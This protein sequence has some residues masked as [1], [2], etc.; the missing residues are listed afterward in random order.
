[1]GRRLRRSG[2]HAG[3]RASRRHERS[4]RRRAWRPVRGS[5][6]SLMLSPTCW[7]M[8]ACA[9]GTRARSRDAGGGRSGAGR[10][11]ALGGA[12]GLSAAE[13]PSPAPAPV[14][15]RQSPLRPQSQEHHV[16]SG[17]VNMTC[18][19]R[20]SEF[21]ASNRTCRNLPRSAEPGACDEDDPAFASDESSALS[22]SLSRLS[23][24]SAVSSESALFWTRDLRLLPSLT[25]LERTRSAGAGGRR[26]VGGV[27]GSG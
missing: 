6:P 24:S 18:S 17:S 5:Q 22:G 9:R 2:W 21:P 27:G 15:L 16:K 7:A 14:R 20:T 1:M 8:A 12:S 13:R 10:A 4:A 26:G 23:R 19:A 25:A 11:A 3:R